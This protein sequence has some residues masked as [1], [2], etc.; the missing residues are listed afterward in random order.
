MPV[1]QIAFHGQSSK[2]VT[3]ENRLP[4]QCLEHWLCK[5]HRRAQK[6]SLKQH[7]EQQDTKAEVRAVLCRA[8][9]PCRYRTTHDKD[10]PGH[11]RESDDDSPGDVTVAG[12]QALLWVTVTS[13]YVV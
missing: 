9:K 13:Q 8:E 3:Q 2:E 6:A 11:A 10:Q 12:C 4:G 7:K 5:Q 1:P